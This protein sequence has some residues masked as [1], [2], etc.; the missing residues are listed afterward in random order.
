MRLAFLNREKSVYPG[1]D[2]NTIEDLTE[3]LRAFNVEATLMQGWWKPEELRS[4][5]LIHIRHCNFSWSQYNFDG[6]KASGIPYV[7]TP[8]FYPRLDLG[9]DKDAIKTALEGAVA[10]IPQ[11][12]REWNE[13]QEMIGPECRLVEAIPNG[14]SER[15]HAPNANGGST[16]HGVLCV[17]ARAGDK[18][19][20]LVETTCMRLGL[21]LRVATSIPHMM[22]PLVYKQYK[23]FVNASD[24]ERM[25]RTVGEALCAGCRVLAPVGNRGNEWYGTRLAVIDPAIDFTS[26]LDHVYNSPTWDFEPNDKA[27]EMTW[28]KSAQRLK[29]L[30][31]K[32]LS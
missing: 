7:V 21:K 10:V 26:I 2:I 27:R 17:T 3:A 32:A 9:M 4:F 16:R 19:V 20:W 22:M 24:S 28:T 23:V 11:S 25:S 15:F 14:T 12:W 1:G 8:M 29:E 30:Y 5:D 13:I 18:N 31:D 6:A